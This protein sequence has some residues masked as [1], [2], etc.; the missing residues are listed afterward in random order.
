[1]RHPAAQH[2]TPSPQGDV[3][4]STVAVSQSTVPGRIGLRVPNIGIAATD[5]VIAGFRLRG[6]VSA[7]DIGGTGSQRW[8]VV[9]NDI[10]CPFG[11]G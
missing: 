1:M 9:N 4:G 8:R 5:W 11:D 10:S 6:D 2:A 3:V 7:M